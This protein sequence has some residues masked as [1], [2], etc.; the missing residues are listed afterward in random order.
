MKV[1][2]TGMGSNHCGR[3]SNTTFFSVMADTVSEFAEVTWAAPKLSWTRKDL[4]QYEAIVF[5]LIPP[6]SLS[7]NRIFG[8]LNV[9]QLMFDSPK[10]KLVAD[11]AQMWQY[12]N[13]VKALKRDPG[14][15]FTSFYSKRADYSSILENRHI[16]ENA[17]SALESEIWP[18]VLYPELP[19]GSAERVATILDFVPSES[20][21]GINLDS[22][23]ISPEP[24]RIG[25]RDNWAVENP[26]STWLPDLQRLLTFPLLPVK[27]GRRTDDDYALGIL[28]NS[29]GLII[30][31]QERKVGS[32]WNYRL[33]QALNTGTP[34][35]TYWQDSCVLDPSWGVLAYTLED[36]DPVQRQ[37]VANSQRYSYVNAIPEKEEAIHN[38]KSNLLNSVKERI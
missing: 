17:V 32:W 22:T 15:L 31:P 24:P 3:P 4:E 6:T 38:L 16:V 10:L 7:A 35:A 19:W 12:R 34:V 29:M 36:Y 11:S 25:R 13:S 23:L 27:V 28:R 37:M 21:T 30:P 26:K 8:A 14:I 5:G 18:T 20:L 1:L 2:F 33:Y 9:L